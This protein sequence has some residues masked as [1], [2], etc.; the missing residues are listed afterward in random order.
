MTGTPAS[1]GGG[2][3]RALAGELISR[4]RWSRARLMD[5]QRQ[6]LN[7]LVRHA[8]TTS[9]FY[10]D[11]LAKWALGG[12]V[13]LSELPTLTKATLMAEFDRIVC[14]PRLRLA[15]LAHYVDGPD[16]SRLY[17]GG[18]RIFVTSANAGAA[19]EGDV[20]RGWTAAMPGVRGLFIYSRA[21]WTLVPANILRWMTFTGSSMDVRLATIGSPNPLHL[22][23][24]AFADLGSV[25]AYG[26]D[27]DPDRPDGLRLEVSM[28]TDEVVTALNEFQPDVVVT[29]PTIASVLAGEQLAGRLQIR[30]QTVLAG[31]DAISDAIRARVRAAWGA[32]LF[33]AYAMTAAG[34][35]G[36]ECPHRTGLHI[37]EDLVIVEAVD[38]RNQP[39]PLGIP[40]AKTL[41]TNLTNYAQPLIRYE[42]SDRVTL[43]PTLCP[44]GR[45][46]ALISR[47]ERRGQRFAEPHGGHHGGSRNG[48]THNGHGNGN[49]HNGHDNGAGNGHRHGAAAHL[50]LIKW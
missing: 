30:P 43:A 32:D 37:A 33:H 6:A 48:N 16:A 15:D 26:D 8:A 29:Y 46:F 23:H 9:P 24:R 4:E 19:T 25:R 36:T 27:R 42:V 47:I 20:G 2:S 50:R 34:L 38:D 1:P 11:R 40:G 49:G 28:P 22:S 3:I 12:D 35:L 18:Y 44:C 39:V 21:E 13:Q 41:I 10:R 45:P 17:L 5:H 14:D 7:A 31:S